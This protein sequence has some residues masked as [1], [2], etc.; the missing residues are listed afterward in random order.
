MVLGK[1]K[2]MVFWGT[3]RRDLGQLFSA[4]FTVTVVLPGKIGS[5]K[6]LI[7]AENGPILPQNRPKNMV[8][9]LIFRP[10]NANGDARGIESFIGGGWIQ[11]HINLPSFTPGPATL[12]PATSGPAASGPATSGPATCDPATSARADFFLIFW[13]GRMAGTRG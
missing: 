12:G 2:K 5:K 11:P 9:L 10:K 13:N 8:F 1:N 6:D 4:V 7:L 3:T